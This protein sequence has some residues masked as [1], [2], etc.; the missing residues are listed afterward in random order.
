MNDDLEIFELTSG[1]K[2]SPFW[3]RLKSWL[4]KQLHDARCHNDNL[5]S[6]EETAAKRGEIQALKRFIALGDEPPII[7]GNDY[8]PR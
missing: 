4:E 5:L 8:G 3:G 2:A 6:A 7:D 1:E